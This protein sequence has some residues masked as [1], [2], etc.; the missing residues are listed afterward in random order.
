MT[1][2]DQLLY[3]Y[4]TFNELIF[5]ANFLLGFI[6]FMAFFLKLPCYL[7]CFYPW[8]ASVECN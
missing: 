1:S 4:S 8:C 6:R 5:Y 7:L 3:R 2:T